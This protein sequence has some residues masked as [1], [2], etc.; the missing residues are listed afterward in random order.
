M[1]I[2]DGHDSLL[3]VGGGVGAGMLSNGRVDSKSKIR[4]F[5]AN[6]TGHPPGPGTVGRTVTHFF[7]F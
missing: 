4:A 6:L 7:V 1:L 2:D 3:D 5:L